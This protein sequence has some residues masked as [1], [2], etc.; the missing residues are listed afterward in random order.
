[1]DSQFERSAL[2]LG[3]ENICRLRQKSVLLFGVG[4]VGSFVAESLARAGI[5]RI[6]LCD[7]DVISESNINRQLIALHSTVGKQKTDVM[8]ARI[9]D[10]N[11]LAIVENFP[12]FFGADTLSQF[13]FSRY[14]YIIDAIDT[15]TAKL[16]IIETAKAKNVPVIS[17]M[18]TGNKLDPTKFTVCDISKTSVCPLAR[19]MRRELKARNINKLNVLFSPEEPISPK[20]NLPQSSSRRSTPGSVPFVPSVAGLIISAFVIKDMLGI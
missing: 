7:N 13:D 19:V 3:E 18:G 1:M 4:G 17:G 6:G 20:Q 5:G 2:L 15:V 8:Q 14:D 11:P 10:I 16:L 9:N 12:I